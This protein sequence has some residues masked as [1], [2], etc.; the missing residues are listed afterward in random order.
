MQYRTGTTGAWTDASHTG[1]TTSLTLKQLKAATAYQV[2]VRATND[3]GTSPWSDAGTGETAASPA[4]VNNDGEVDVKDLAAVGAHIGRTITNA[5]EAALD[6][7]DD[8]KVDIADLQAVLDALQ[9]CEVGGA[10]ASALNIETLAYWIEAA[11]EL[12]LPDLTCQTGVANLERLLASLTV[13]SE[14][15]LLANYPNPFNPDT[16]I[17][18]QLATPVDV[19]LTIYA[20][21]GA[22]I[23]VLEIGHQAAGIYQSRSRA[24]YWDG[25]NAQGE[26]VA[27]GVYFYTLTAGNFSATKKMVIRK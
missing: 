4:D 18:Y 14:T 3:E 5:N 9:G 25:R 24:A 16:W 12:N 11:K 23:R 7:N 1:A 8:D 2:R 20:A 13:P 6:V 15:N 26:P 17:P 22:V 21:N 27:S 10:P 19:T